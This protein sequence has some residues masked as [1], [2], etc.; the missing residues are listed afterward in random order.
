[1]AKKYLLYIHNSDRFDRCRN[2]SVLVN[3]LLEDHFSLD[4]E[5]VVPSSPPVAVALNIKEAPDTTLHIAKTANEYKYCKKGHPY[6][7]PRCMQK[8]C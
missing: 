6:R 5:L 4:R 3:A 8:G 2:K 1:M 7:G